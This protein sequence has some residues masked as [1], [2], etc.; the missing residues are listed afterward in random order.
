MVPVL[1]LLP[2]LS[3]FTRPPLTLRAV[4]GE[5]TLGI[6]RGT[7]LGGLPEAA[8]AL[9]EIGSGLLVSKADLV[10]GSLEPLFGA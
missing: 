4:G 8:Q 9:Q 1:V 6:F 2:E 5:N 10:L 7:D 3:R